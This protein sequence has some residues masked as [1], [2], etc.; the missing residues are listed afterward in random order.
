LAVSICI[1]ISQALAEPLRQQLYQTPGSKLFLA[2]AKKSVK[3]LFVFNIYS[4]AVVNEVCG[5][6]WVP[7][8]RAVGNLGTNI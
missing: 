1:Y 3:I 2:S 5:K 7:Y 6:T 4:E 8:L